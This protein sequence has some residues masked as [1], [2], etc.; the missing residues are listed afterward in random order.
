[1]PASENV[2]MWR[3]AAGTSAGVRAAMPIFAAIGLFITTINWDWTLTAH[4]ATRGSS[5]AQSSSRATTERR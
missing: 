5:S 4:A 1:M 3:A 2:A